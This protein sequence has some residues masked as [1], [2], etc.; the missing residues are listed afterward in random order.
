MRVLGGTVGNYG[1]SWS[2]T[3]SDIV[4]GGGIFSKG[5]QEIK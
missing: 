4:L 2:E 5:K 3:E 1:A